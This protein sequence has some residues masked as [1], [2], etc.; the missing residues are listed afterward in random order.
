MPTTLGQALARAE[1]IR[2]GVRKLAVDF[3]GR[4]LA[5][6]TVSIGVAALPEHGLSPDALLG[7]ADAALYLAKSDGRDRSKLAAQMGF[8]SGES[9]IERALPR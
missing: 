2:V 7:V 4:T 8:A 9:S 1:Q 6:V 3:H 5:G